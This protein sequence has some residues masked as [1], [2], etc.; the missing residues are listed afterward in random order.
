MTL[1]SF[2]ATRDSE[3]AYY[4]V[5]ICFNNNGSKIYVNGLY[6]PSDKFL[7]FSQ[8]IFDYTTIFDEIDKLRNGN[9]IIRFK[10]WTGGVSV[11]NKNNKISVNGYSGDSNFGCT[12]VYNNIEEFITSFTKTFNDI[13]GLEIF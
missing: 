5:E 2:Y 7:Q 8:S 12:I 9:G 13:F 6:D 4:N 10:S 1:V 11:N 3:G